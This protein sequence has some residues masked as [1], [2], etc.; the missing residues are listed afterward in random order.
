MHKVTFYPIG[1]AD[2]SFI[3]LNN[4]QNILFDYAHTKIAEDEK[5]LRIDLKTTILEKM[6]EK[7]KDYIDVVAFTHAD[8]DHYKGFSDIFYLE[9]AKKY[10]DD[11]RLKIND[12]WIPAELIVETELPSE[13]KILQSEGR[14]RLKAKKGIKIFSRPEAI[15]CW[16]E[17]EG[18]NID[19]FRDLFVD[20]GKYVPGFSFKKNDLEIF[21]HSPFS[22]LEDGKYVDR[23]LGSIVVQFNFI[24]NSQETRMILSADTPYDNWQKIVNIT[25]FKRNNERLNWDI[26]KIPHHCSYNSLGPEKG[27]TKTIPVEEVSWLLDQGNFRGYIISNSNPI[28]E[29]ESDQP[30]HFQ[31][32]NCYKEKI[33]K[34][35][36]EF[37]V[38]MEFPKE[39]DPKP[40]VIEIDESGSKVI[41][42]T[43]GFTPILTKP[44]KRAG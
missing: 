2:C 34:L 20:A 30:P 3:E 31:A 24:V 22:I 39:S 38:T 32:K 42:R 21:V 37:I 28:K 9:H 44:A 14:Y 23:N 29:V 41:K 35:N 6:D 13:A 33:A 26:F 16:F 19:N 1:N 15:K 10:Q 8:E 12:L 36:C 18:L 17:K 4:G 5:D 7:E 27:K 11:S 25:K 40:L 43:L